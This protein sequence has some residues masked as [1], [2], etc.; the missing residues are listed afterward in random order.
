MVKERRNQPA[1][2]ISV[3]MI[4]TLRMMGSPASECAALVINN[5]SAEIPSELL[6]ELLAEC[7]NGMVSS[8]LSGT[9][10]RHP[11]AGEVSELLSQFDHERIS[12]VAEM[13][14]DA[15]ERVEWASEL[16]LAFPRRKLDGLSTVAVADLDTAITA[17]LADES[18]RWEFLLTLSEEWEQSL[19]SLISA[20]LAMDINE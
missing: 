13:I 17:Q 12:A 3:D 14:E 7:S 4:R 16:L 8:F 6:T 19:S 2:A 9:S 15:V 10:N 1:G 20:A 11:R 5:A 18:A